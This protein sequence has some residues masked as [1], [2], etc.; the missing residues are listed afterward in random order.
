MKS[1]EQFKQIES[2]ERIRLKNLEQEGKWIFHGSG[3]QIEILEPKQAYNHPKNSDEDKIL[4]DK[5]A[6]F[7]SPSADI[8]IFMAIV[9]RKNAPKGFRSGFSTNQNGIE[10]RVTKETIE[11]IHDAKGYVYVFDKDKFTERSPSEFLSYKPVSPVETIEV[12]DKDL[13]T[14]IVIKDF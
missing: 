7:A 13:P 14:G 12:S 8:A 9:N 1:P 2:S 4:D 10:F 11:Q 5:P 3:S 6:V